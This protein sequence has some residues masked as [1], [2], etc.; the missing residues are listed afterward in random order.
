M[1]YELTTSEDS[2]FCCE[3]HIEIVSQ[4]WKQLDEYKKYPHKCVVLPRLIKEPDWSCGECEYQQQVY[5]NT[6]VITAD[7][8]NAKKD[9]YRKNISLYKQN[10]K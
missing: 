5:D 6:P 4:Y 1:W 2:V 3:Q 7:L 8:S 9:K 10:E